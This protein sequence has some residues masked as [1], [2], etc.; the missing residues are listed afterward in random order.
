VPILLDDFKK[1]KKIII[2]GSVFDA[3][4]WV[5]YAVAVGK[6]ELAII[7]AITE[8]YPALAI[9]YG[10]KFNKEKISKLQYIGAALAIGVSLIITLIS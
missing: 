2:L 4:A 6:Q 3:T 8:S 9:F 7:T 1:Y 10:V 5:F